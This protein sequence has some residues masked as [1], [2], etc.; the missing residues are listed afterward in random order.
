MIGIPTVL[1]EC[2]SCGYKDEIELEKCDNL[3]NDLMKLGAGWDYE[4]EVYILI[5]PIDNQ[6]WYHISGNQIWCNECMK[7]YNP[8]YDPREEALTAA[9]RNVGSL[10]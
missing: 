7:E 1:V 4:D 6:C 10:I 9:E 3:I 5:N 8:N 2:D